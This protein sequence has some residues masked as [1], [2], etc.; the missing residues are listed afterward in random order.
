MYS[1]RYHYPRDSLREDIKYYFADFVRKGGRGG[2]GYPQ[3][4]NPLFAEIFFRKGWG[5]VP[6]ISVTYFSDQKQVFF[7]QKNTICSPF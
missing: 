6:P 3:F 4:R 2:G 5:G 1:Q 7:G